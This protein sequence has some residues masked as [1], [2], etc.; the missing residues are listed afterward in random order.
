MN[1]LASAHSRIQLTFLCYFVFFFFQF[2]NKKINVTFHALMVLS[3]FSLSG[4][5]SHEKKIADTTAFTWKK[6][7][8]QKLCDCFTK[9]ETYV[10]SHENFIHWYENT[11]R[12]ILKGIIA[13]AFNT[14]IQFEE[15]N[16]IWIIGRIKWNFN[17]LS[18]QSLAAF[19][20]IKTDSTSVD[21]SSNSLNPF[22]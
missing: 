4:I 10:G 5:Y 3:M 20:Q 11:R 19:Y 8:N 21:S 9:D 6:S 17:F 14:R 7:T 18:S 13:L 2:E 16:Y 12:D 15:I 22:V 1:S